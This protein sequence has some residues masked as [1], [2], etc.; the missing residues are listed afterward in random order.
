[1]GDTA[2]R[3]LSRLIGLRDVPRVHLRWEDPEALNPDDVYTLRDLAARIASAAAATGGVK[4]HPSAAVMHETWT[5]A[6][7][8]EVTSAVE[9]LGIAVGELNNRVSAAAAR[10][11]VDP[12]D[13]SL[14]ELAT[15]DEL[16]SLLLNA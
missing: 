15:F 5:P 13:W 14:D 2:F 12:S 11:G 10:V 7:E 4:T 3:A 9:A 8:A 1:T 16:A 6:W